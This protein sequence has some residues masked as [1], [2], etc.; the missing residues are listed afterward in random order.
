MAVV[1]RDIEGL[2]YEEIAGALQV[3]LGTVKSR[4]RERRE[5]LKLKLLA[6]SGPQR[7][8]DAAGCG[9]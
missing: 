2:T 8:R 6:L 1:L 5:S 7:S 4:I 9:G 3:S